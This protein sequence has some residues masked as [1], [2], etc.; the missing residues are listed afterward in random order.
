MKTLLQ[1]LVLALLATTTTVPV[2]A[3]GYPEKPIRLIVPWPAGG[4]A[5]SIG[6]VLATTLAAELGTTV[7]VDNVAGA[8]GT[9]GNQQLIRAQPDG[10]T[11]LLASSSGNASAP[12]L[13]KK[14]GFDPIKDFRPVGLVAMAPSVLVVPAGSPF[15]TPK[16]IISTA[17]ANPGKLSYGSGGNGNSGHLSGELFKSIAKIEATHVPYKGNTPAMMD[18]IGGQL[19]FMFDNGAIPFIKGGKIRALAVAA[20]T[21]MTA[22]PNVPTF[23]EAG[24]P[25]MH[26]STWFGLAVP[27]ATPAPIVSRLSTALNAAL[28]SPEVSKRFVD[29]GAEVHSSS[30]ESFADYWKKE[31]DRYKELIKLSGAMVE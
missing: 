12:A 19:D 11:I 28:K 22:L 30:P 26:L 15:K 8:S 23:A 21:R 16:D 6:R 5:D 1:K 13:I 18:L 3:E 24:F 31:L 25:A 7:F 10:H 4:S 20:E 14:L 9:I 29:M 27:A 2:M 17:M